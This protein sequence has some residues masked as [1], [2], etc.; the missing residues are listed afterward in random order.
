MTICHCGTVDGRYP[1][2]FGMELVLPGNALNSTGD[3]AATLTM[4]G[5][6]FSLSACLDGRGNSAHKTFRCTPETEPQI[7]TLLPCRPDRT[8]DLNGPG[9][10][11]EDVWRPP[12]GVPA[13]S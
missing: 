12:G 10:T 6:G 2:I 7:A 3:Q 4:G 5:G 8:P 11:T 9:R 1:L 13:V